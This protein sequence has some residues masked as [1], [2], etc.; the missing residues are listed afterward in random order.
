MEVVNAISTQL[1]EYLNPCVVSTCLWGT[2]VGSKL[3]AG[4][5]SVPADIPNA[6]DEE[7]AYFWHVLIEDPFFEI[8][9]MGETSIPDCGFIPP[10]S[11]TWL[12]RLTS[13]VASRQVEGLLGACELMNSFLDARA[14]ILGSEVAAPL[15][16]R[17]TSA[18][19]EPGRAVARAIIARMAQQSIAQRGIAPDR[20]FC[21]VLF[22]QLILDLGASERGIADWVLKLFGGLAASSLTTFVERK[23]S[24]FAVAAAP[25]PGD[26]LFYLSHGDTIRNFI[27]DGLR[28]FKPTVIIAHSLG[29]VATF[30]SLLVEHVEGVSHF[31]TLG[32]QVSLFYELDCLSQL[33]F[34]MP[35]P[36]IFPHWLNLYDRRD[37]L[38][39]VCG[40]VFGDKRVLDARV[41][42]G[43]H[44][45]ASHSAYWTNH[46]TWK[47]I[48]AF[49]TAQSV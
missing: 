48:G 21:D 16:S 7:R 2:A 40:P 13:S 9:V 39:F 10:T 6:D 5:L 4:G 19:M 23:R 29:G 35:V 36:E 27:I 1:S 20:R 49:L 26:I 37:L 18:S 28:S 42:S 22:D 25:L 30:E 11:E 17:P 8:R 24:T 41:E 43:L 45:P 47:S 31:I 46:A 34:G 12:D 44:F 14:F 33:R 3:L 15:L 32:S 38:S